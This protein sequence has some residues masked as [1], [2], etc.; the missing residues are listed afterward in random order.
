MGKLQVV[1]GGQAG[2]EGKGAIAAYLA[3][4]HRRGLSI[5]VAGP[6][7]GHTVIG[8]CPPDCME[9]YLDPAVKIPDHQHDRHPWRLQQVP[10]AVV[11]N[12]TET[13]AIAAG[14]EVDL[15]ILSR[16]VRSLDAAGYH[17]SGR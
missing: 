17:V 6:N 15:E 4:E 5:R 3:R 2:S 12:Q 11:T 8:R 9:Q 10:V 16:E 13:L 1:V 14:S 7:A